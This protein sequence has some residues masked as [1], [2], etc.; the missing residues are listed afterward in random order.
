MSESPGDTKSPQGTAR[1]RVRQNGR[2]LATIREA[3]GY[4]QSGLARKIGMTQA[5]LWRIENER[6]NARVSTLIRIARAL[7]VDDVGAIMRD[8]EALLEEAS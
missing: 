7:P 8:P 1:R 6:S 4:S 2:A 3:Y 5:N